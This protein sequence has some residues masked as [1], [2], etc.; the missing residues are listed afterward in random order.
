L[1]TQAPSSLVEDVEVA[2]FS[3]LISPIDISF[4]HQVTNT[5]EEPNLFP[6]AW[7]HRDELERNHWREAI[8]KEIK[9]MI[10]KKVW[11]GMSLEDVPAGRTPIGSKWVFKKK[12]NGVYRARLVAL[13]YNQVAGVDYTASFAPVVHD[14]TY[15]IV[16]VLWMLKNWTSTV[17]DVETAFLYGDLE[18][19]IYMK[20]PTGLK[21]YMAE[22]NQVVQ[23][24]HVLLLTKS[25]YGLVQAARQ[26][27]AK[28]T[29]ILSLDMGFKRSLIDPCLLHGKR[30]NGDIVLCLYVDD[31]L[32]VGDE[33][34]IA[35]FVV[36][37]SRKFTIKNQ[38]PL[39]EYVGCK[40]ISNNDRSKVW[41]TQPDMVKKLKKEFNDDVK[42]MQTYAAPAAPG[43]IIM[44]AQEASELISKDK[45]RNYRKGVG[46]LLCMVKHSRPDISNAVRELSK[47]MDGATE[48]H[49]N[50]LHRVIKNVLDTANTSLLM[51]PTLGQAKWE[52]K[53]YSDSDYG[54]DRD[55][56]RSVSGYIIFL[57]GAPIVWRSKMQRSVTL[58]ST[59]AE[60]V[61]LS[62]VV[63]EIMF[64]KQ[65]LEFLEIPV[66]LP[67]EVHVDNVGAIFLAT[68]ATTGQRT[69]HIDVR[70]HY[71]REYIEDGQVIIRFVKSGD[72]KADPYTKNTSK[73]IYEKHTQ[74]YM[75]ENEMVRNREGVGIHE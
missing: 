33:P 74:A 23:T 59:E 44:R 45:Q 14:A 27:W 17:L 46:M 9:S 63:T 24:N 66:T 19:S 36:E 53:A 40:V 25:I 61:A 13:G 51:E 68:N 37:L 42:G 18:E 65:V 16:L 3:Q 11:R 55:Q 73:E 75:D 12:K 31:V 64:A 22:K 49:I 43:E 39:D 7:N 10:E 26:W 48:G 58:S 47:V 35:Q 52:L 6:E 69:R 67:I 8:K 50:S 5:D 15:R 34:A 28:F 2:Y 32:C 4:I 71:V 57:A 1:R 70:Y 41:I 21:E 62:D 54:G 38:G 29:N 56:R 20:T 72:N 60:Y 30:E